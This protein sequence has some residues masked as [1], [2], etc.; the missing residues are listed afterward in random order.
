MDTE[1]PILKRIQKLLTL[2]KDKG[3]SKAEA[4]R[5]MEMAQ[6]LMTKYNGNGSTAYDKIQYHYGEYRRRYS[7][8]KDKT[9][10][11]LLK[12]GSQSCRHGNNR[13]TLQVLQ[14]ENLI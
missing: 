7:R 8:I 9:R 3:A 5:A 6:R 4:E 12:G 11:L 13:N 2:S 1:K 10:I 14:G